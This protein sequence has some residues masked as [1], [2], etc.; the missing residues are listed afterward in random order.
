MVQSLGMSGTARGPV[1]SGGPAS[2]LPLIA[3]SSTACPRVRCAACHDLTVPGCVQRV[4]AAPPVQAWPAA[5]RHTQHLP[6]CLWDTPAPLIVC[7]DS[8]AAWMGEPAGTPHIL[9][10]NCGC[11]GE[12]QVVRAA[13]GTLCYRQL[14]DRGA[15]TPTA[16]CRWYVPSPSRPQRTGAPFI[17]S[18]SVSVGALPGSDLGQFVGRL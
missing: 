6:V 2:S 7:R 16:R 17:P 18:S 1:H 12:L 9:K 8:W 13:G 5:H 10:K 15:C 14:L 11:K 4:G 3:A